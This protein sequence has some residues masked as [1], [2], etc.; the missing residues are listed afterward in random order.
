MRRHLLRF[1]GIERRCAH[2]S[3][4]GEEDVVEPRAGCFEAALPTL[5]RYCRR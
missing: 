3:R 4:L 2:F 5:R 1:P